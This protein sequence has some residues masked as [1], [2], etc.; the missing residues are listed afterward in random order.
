MQPSR[1]ISPGCC[2]DAHMDLVFVID[3]SSAVDFNQWQTMLQSI[4][5]MLD[6]FTINLGRTNVCV[7]SLVLVLVVLSS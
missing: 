7:V 4:V 3:S 2:V 5:D 6:H 1:E